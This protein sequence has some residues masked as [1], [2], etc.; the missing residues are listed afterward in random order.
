MKDDELAR[1]QNK[2]DLV[3]A[4][5]RE[6]PQIWIP[7]HRLAHVGGFAAWRTRISEARTIAE[8]DGFTIVWN[9]NVQDSC[10]MYRP[11]S[12]ARAAENPPAGWP[13]QQRDLF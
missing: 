8:R 3:L 7:I 11:I 12:V 4:L 5:F 9:G 10:Y 2:T 6:L 13:V 1:R